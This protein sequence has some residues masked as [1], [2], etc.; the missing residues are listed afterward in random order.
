MVPNL[1][2]THQPE[3]VQDAV[4]THP[5]HPSPVEGGSNRTSLCVVNRDYGAI[6][7]TRKR[8]PRIIYKPYERKAQEPCSWTSGLVLA[9]N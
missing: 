1:W 8:R 4:T 6:P 2:C 3:V 9:F 7:K 5:D